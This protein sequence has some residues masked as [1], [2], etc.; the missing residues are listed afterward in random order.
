[1]EQITAQQIQAG[2][3]IARDARYDATEVLSVEEGP[4]ANT[5]LMRSRPRLDGTTTIVRIRPRH[6]TPFWRAS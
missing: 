3:F 6:S 4:R 1:M 5:I 2:D